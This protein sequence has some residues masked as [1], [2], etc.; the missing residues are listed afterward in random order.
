MSALKKN[1][2]ISPGAHAVDREYRV[3]S[4]LHKYSHS[5]I[6]DDP[7]KKDTT[8]PVP[9]PLLFCS[10]ASVIGT[11]FFCYGFVEG[12]FFKSPQLKSVR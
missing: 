12:R 5:K 4:A 2:F 9:H 1:V 3:M 7:K 10:D 11:P 6:T 8:F